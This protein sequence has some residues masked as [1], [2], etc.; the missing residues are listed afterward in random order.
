L[1]FLELKDSSKAL[2]KIDTKPMNIKP[3]ELCKIIR[4]SL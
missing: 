4:E 3:H 1:V 2:I